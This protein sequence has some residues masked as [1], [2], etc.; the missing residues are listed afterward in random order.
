MKKL[1][2]SVISDSHITHFGAGKEEFEN[3]LKFHSEH[4]NDDAFVFL[5][6]IVYQLDS[7]G[8]SVCNNIY[9]SNYDFVLDTIDKYVSGTTEKLYVLGNHEFP[10]NNDD[11][12]LNRQ[13]ISVWKEKFRQPIKEH[14]IINGYHF[15][16][17][18]VK[19]WS[20]PIDKDDEMWLIEEIEKAKNDSEN[21]PVFV[22]SHDCMPDTVVFSGQKSSFSPE[23][24]Q[25]LSKQNNVIHITGHNHFHICDEK[26]IFQDGFTTISAPQCGVG[27][28]VF[29][30]CEYNTPP[31]FGISQGLNFEV[32]DNTVYVHRIDYT[33][34]EFCDQPW[35]IDINET[36]QGIFRYDKNRD[37]KYL[38]NSFA[39]DAY[40]EAK[41][42]G[43]KVEI[44]IRQS[45]INNYTVE[46]YRMDFVDADG[47]I[48][49]SIIRPTDFYNIIRDIPVRETLS[50]CISNIEKGIYTLC[51]TS[52]NCFFEKG[53]RELKTKV[54]IK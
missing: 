30:G 32:I 19:A 21:M 2:F 43:D 4:F 20:M 38:C 31:V 10:Q 23:A 40:V 45:F 53:E 27:C 16:K 52:F 46:Y 14:R 17:Y 5:G 11:F 41:Q 26:S 49:H 51:V 7:S 29:E 8:K 42:T 9:S 18:P 44:N 33:S 39:E 36:S 35:I 47:K 34:G 50:F 3:A 22:I 24:R 15:I 48:A 12:E 6:D 13:A 54:E 28:V 37:D 25:Y 1:R